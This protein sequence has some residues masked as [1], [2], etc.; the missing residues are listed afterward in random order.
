[1]RLNL[2][3]L[4]EWKNAVFQVSNVFENEEIEEF[5]KSVSKPL[6]TIGKQ[7]VQ[8]SHCTAFRDLISNHVLVKVKHGYQTTSEEV[9][10]AVL[11]NTNAQLLQTKGNILL[12]LS[13]I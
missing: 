11:Q 3:V 8:S 6:L 10:N 13:G 7:G 1:M 4:I 2:G 12:F 9:V 5:W